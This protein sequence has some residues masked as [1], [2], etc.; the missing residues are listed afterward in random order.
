MRNTRAFGDVELVPRF[1]RDVGNIS[2]R[3]Q[4]L[5]CDLE[6]PVMLSP[7][8]MSRLFHEDGELAVARAAAAQ[9]TLYTLSTV[10]TESIEAV[11]Q[12]SDGARMFQ[13]YVLGDHGLNREFI[14]RSRAAGYRALCLTVDVPTAGNREQDI[15]TGMAIP[16]Q[17]TLG[18]KLSLVLHPRWSL[19]RWFGK[20]FDLPNVSHLVP[21]GSDSLAARMGFIFKQ[22]DPAVT[23][24][25][26]EAMVEE[27]NAPFAI[28]GILSPADAIKAVE[29]GA[30]AV[31]VSNH[32]G[33]QLDSAPSTFDCLADIVDAVAGRA[34]VIID[35]GIR[36]GTDVIKAMAMGATACMIGR[37]YVYGLTIAGQAGV[38]HALNIFRTEIERDLALVGCADIRDL[39]RS[40]LRRIPHG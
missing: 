19:A 35:G 9:G 7:T 20:D 23:W 26:A 31:I 12:A 40:Y 34:E 5:G 11:A 10:A 21:E 38:E 24:Q 18:S 39:D 1:L 6:L 3:T 16:P 2:T 33:R 17:F 13:L 32:G 15:R 22:F 28:K 8:G 36:R 25:H 29:I 4:A 30:S 37:P 14:Q 27:W